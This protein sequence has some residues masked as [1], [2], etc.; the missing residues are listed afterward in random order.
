LQDE[1]KALY[2]VQ[3]ENRDGKAELLEIILQYLINNS[4]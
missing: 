3:A 4:N 1:M 2:N